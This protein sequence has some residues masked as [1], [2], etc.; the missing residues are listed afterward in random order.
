MPGIVKAFMDELGAFKG[1]AGNPLIGYLVQSGFPEGAHS[2]FV[3]RY[4][5]KLAARLS[6]LY[7]GTFVRGGAEGTRLMPEKMN[8]KLFDT[9]RGLGSSFARPYAS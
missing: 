6:S 5:E 1:R 9:Q 3:E 2:R 4:L 7:L 8:R